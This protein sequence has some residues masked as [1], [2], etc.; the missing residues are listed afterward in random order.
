MSDPSCSHSYFLGLR[1]LE[2]SHLMYIVFLKNTIVNL[3]IFCF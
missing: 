1:M 3:D 2:M